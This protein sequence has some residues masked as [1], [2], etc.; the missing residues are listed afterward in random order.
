MCKF[1]SSCKSKCMKACQQAC[2][3]ACAEAKA[4]APSCGCCKP[5]RCRCRCVCRCCCGPT[6]PI[7]PTGPTGPTV[8]TG[9]TIPTG[10]TPPPPTGPTPPPPTGPVDPE[11]P[12]P[13]PPTGP[14]PGPG[15]EV[16]PDGPSV[17][18]APTIPPTVPTAPTGSANCPACP[19]GANCATCTVPC[20]GCQVVTN[21]YTCPASVP[22]ITNP[23]PDP[24]LCDNC[25]PEMA[26]EII[27]LT[28]YQ[29]QQ[30]GLAPLTI[31]CT[32]Q[33]YAARKSCSMVSTG[34]MSHPDPNGQT[35]LDWMIA[36]GVTQFQTTWHENLAE[37]T[38]GYESAC[39]F[40]EM[41]NSDCGHLQN[42][43]ACEVTS[44][45]VAVCSDGTN[46]YVAQEFG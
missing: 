19:N 2:R 45:G 7:G 14:T 29:R 25:D 4:S 35:T 1:N 32:L 6:G 28:N 23:C 27:A 21:A 18:T 13:P 3:E 8:P 39:Q 5:K 22:T 15:G 17:P 10:P 31:D 30:V 46:T 26:L 42:L 9:P 24:G 20:V 34:I 16:D 36:D 38:S 37:Y 41:W 40:M 12:T 33:Q 43:L 11:G 44:I